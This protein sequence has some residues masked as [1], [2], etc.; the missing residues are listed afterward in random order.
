MTNEKLVTEMLKLVKAFEVAN[1][2]FTEEWWGMRILATYVAL[3]AGFNEDQI[4]N[5]L[6]AQMS[7]KEA[8]S[9]I[10]R[11]EHCSK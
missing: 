6:C 7:E 3:F 8:N 5:I 10:D 9:V 2:C 4:Y 1:R 11:F